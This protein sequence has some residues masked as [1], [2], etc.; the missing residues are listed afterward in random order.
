MSAVV[1]QSDRNPY[2]AI[3]GKG[4]P[5]KPVRLAGPIEL[6]GPISMIA[7]HDHLQR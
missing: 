5:A 7:V 2:S 4:E 6:I 3:G 1:S